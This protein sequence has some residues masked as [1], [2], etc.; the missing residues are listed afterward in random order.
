MAF[1][2]WLTAYAGR[3]HILDMEGQHYS[4]IYIG[5]LSNH[6]FWSLM[7]SWAESPWTPSD[8]V[9]H[10]WSVSSVQLLS[11]VRLP[12]IPWTATRQAS[13]P[14]TNFRSLLKLMSIESVM[15]SNHLILCHHLLLSP[16]IFSSIRVCSNELV[17]CIS[18][19]SQ[20]WSLYL[21][22]VA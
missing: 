16:S 9:L 13:L 19:P 5:D 2:D 11:H 10:S 7:R 21:L 8:T 17:L 20:L 18:W 3:P 1:G 22:S 14:V 6:R 15:P 4:T 12:E